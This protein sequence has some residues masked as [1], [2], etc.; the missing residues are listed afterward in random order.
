MKR[1]KVKK[2][3]KKDKTVP[4]KDYKYH[5]NLKMNSAIKEKMEKSLPSYNII[6]TEN[7]RF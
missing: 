6:L 3:E 4:L 7:A 2:E 5:K 1:Y